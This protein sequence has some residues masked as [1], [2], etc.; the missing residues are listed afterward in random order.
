MRLP[1]DPDNWTGW[2]ADK[3]LAEARRL[4]D[5]YEARIDFTWPQERQDDLYRPYWHAREE[6]IAVAR[7][8]G[9]RKAEAECLP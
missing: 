5:R 6:A 3:A 7:Y 1:K 4:F 9:W 8:T 2:H